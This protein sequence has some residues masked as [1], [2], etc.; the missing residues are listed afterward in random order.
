MS[1]IG[2]GTSKIHDTHRWRFGFNAAGRDWPFPDGCAFIATGSWPTDSSSPLFLINGFIETADLPAR[3]FER[4]VTAFAVHDS[5]QFTPGQQRIQRVN[6][7]LTPQLLADLPPITQQTEKQLTEWTEFLRWKE[8]L[9]RHKARGLR[10]ISREWRDE[11]LVFSLVAQSAQALQKARKALG[12]D[13]LVAFQVGQSKD[14]WVFGL[15]KGRSAA[16]PGWGRLA[17]S[18]SLYRYRKI[19]N[20]SRTKTCRNVLGL[21]LCLPN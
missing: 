2:S 16:F 17:G 11:Q 3:S 15:L 1:P 7:L 10:Y 8:S 13:D 20:I 4:E 21:R 5:L 18:R 6:N 19:E 9:I 14:P 12:R